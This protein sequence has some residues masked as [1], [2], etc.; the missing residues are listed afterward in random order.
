MDFN[1]SSLKGLSEIT[2][3]VL[4]LVFTVRV[5]VWGLVELARLWRDAA[6]ERNAVDSRRNEIDSKRNE[7]DEKHVIV[8]DEVSLRL[9]LLHESDEKMQI[10]LVDQHKE[11]RARVISHDSKVDSLVDE[12][13][14]TRDAQYRSLQQQLDTISD[15]L[16]NLTLCT[17]DVPEMIQ[18][19]HAISQ[20][21]D[22]LIALVKQESE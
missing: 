13:R 6:K 18:E 2:I 9:K 4:G 20:I 16:E 1:P 21:I 7:I 3:L 8:L 22:E 14:E 15:R 11:T 17:K 12:F 5:I 19:V 10:A